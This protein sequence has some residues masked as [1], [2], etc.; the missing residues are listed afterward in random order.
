MLLAVHFVHNLWNIVS[1]S[2][3]RSRDRNETVSV[4]A[5]FKR[6]VKQIEKTYRTL[7]GAVSCV[8]GLDT[9]KKVVRQA[10]K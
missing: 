5:V 4:K 3:Y 1:E 10:F 2:M 7:G 8:G 9:S 6:K